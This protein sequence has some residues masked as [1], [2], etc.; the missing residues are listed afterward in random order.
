MKREIYLIRH[1]SGAVK[2]GYSKNPERRVQAL[3]VMPY[4]VV[5]LEFSKCVRD[6]KSVEREL[7][8]RYS[9]KQIRGEWFD[10]SESEV[11]ELK[12][13]LASV[14]E[15]QVL[16]HK[17]GKKRADVL[18]VQEKRV[19]LDYRGGGTEWLQKSEI[20]E[21]WVSFHTRGQPKMA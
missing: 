6:A 15:G 13:W 17:S 14:G 19:K 5:E 9:D 11:E 18:K 7:H 21:N 8:E 16:E 20:R 10:L 1:D 4:P 2:I 3:D 12:Q